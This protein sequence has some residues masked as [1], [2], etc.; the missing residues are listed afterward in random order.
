MI[1]NFVAIPPERLD[2]L[3]ADP[4]QISAVLYPEDGD[5][6]LPHRLDIDKAWHAIHYTL[7]GKPWEGEGPLSLVVMGGEEIGDD[8]GYGPARYLTPQE[9]KDVAEALAAIDSAKFSER[10]NPALMDSEEIYPQVWE[11]DGDEGL[12]YVL[13]YYNDLSSFYETAAERGDAVLIF[14]N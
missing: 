3:I 7:N 2:Q 8:V 13:D 5:A 4:D 1:G 6:G 11:R 10:F 14:V 12:E 9:V